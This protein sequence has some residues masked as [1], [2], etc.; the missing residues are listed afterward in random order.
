MIGRM[1]T[2]RF[3]SPGHCHRLLQEDFWQVRHVARRISLTYSRVLLCCFFCGTA[4]GT[5]M[6]NCLSAEL[7]GQLGSLGLAGARGQS[8]SSGP[9]SVQ[10]QLAG[11]RRRLLRCVARQRLTEFGLAALVGMTP[12]SSAA[13][14]AAFFGGGFLNGLLVAV[15]TL[16]K[17]LWALPEFFAV[18]L[19]QW[20]CYLPAWAI[21]AAGA[22]DGTACLKVR[23]WLLL[24]VLAAAGML[25]ETF[26]N[27]YFLRF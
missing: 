1:R 9:V 19:P 16:K 18:L 17:G 26:V 23:S 2:G 11:Q 25:L 5:I 12:L 24:A 10:S 3:Y 15:L 13:F 22:E 7:L 20:I 8:G 21:M 14:A 4:A 6:A 27:P